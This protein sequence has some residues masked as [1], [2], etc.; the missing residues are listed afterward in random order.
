AV[1]TAIVQRLWNILSAA[2]LVSIAVGM[3]DLL[4]GRA[5]EHA[6]SRVQ[7]PGLFYD[8]EARDAIGK[9]GAIK[10]MIANMP[11]RRYFIETLDF[12]LSPRDCSPGTGM[13][14]CLVKAITAEALGTA[15]GSVAYNAGQ[16]FGGTGY[17]EDDLLSKYY[18]D[19]SAWRFLGPENADVYRRRGAELL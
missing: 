10:K 5:I 14:S 1:D 2:D 16:I 6:T 17:S 4:C 12:T 18:R 9:F 19:A 15:P 13:R 7:F 11:A 3:A 8:D